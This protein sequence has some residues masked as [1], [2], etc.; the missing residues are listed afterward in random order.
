MTD[1]SLIKRKSE[2]YFPSSIKLVDNATPYNY[3]LIMTYGSLVLSES[4]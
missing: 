2:D 4:Q 1:T 3:Y